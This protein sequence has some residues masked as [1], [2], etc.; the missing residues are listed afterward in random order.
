MGH[1]QHRPDGRHARG[2]HPR[3][4]RLGRLHRI[5]SALVAIIDAGTDYNHPDLAANIWTNPGEIPGNGIDDDG[6]GYVD[7]VHGYDFVNRD[8][9]PMDDNGHGTHVAGTIGAIGDNGVG[10]AGVCW[11][12]K[13]MPLK[14]LDS[15]GFGNTGNAILAVQYATQMHARIMN[16]SWGGGGY[17]EALRLAI[18]AASDAGILF[19][20]AAGNDAADNDTLPHYPANYDVPLV[21]SVASTD[22]FDNLSYFSCY[23]ATTVDLAAP[24]SAILST[25]PNNTYSIYSGTSMATPHVSGALALML[26]R[27]PSMSGADAKQMLLRSVDPLPSLAGRVL[28]GG[29]LNAFTMLAEPDS[30]PPAAITDV[31]VTAVDGSWV[32]LAWTASGDD[33]AVGRASR[34]DVR[35]SLSPITEANF[36]AASAAPGMPYPQPAGTP[37]SVRVNGLAFETPYWFAVKALDEFGNAS[38]M[39]NVASGTTLPGPHVAI[40]PDSL[41][42]DLYTGASTT[43]TLGIANTGASELVWHLSIQETA[44]PLSVAALRSVAAS[45]WQVL[46]QVAPTGANRA[47]SSATVEA[48]RAAFTGVRSDERIL[49]YS[50]EVGRAPGQHYADLALQALGLPYTGIYNDPYSFGAALT[51]GSWDFVFVNHCNYYAVGQWWNE[52]RATC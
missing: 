43:R 19:V 1:A 48:V 27:F 15:G 45:K 50:D 4:E 49:L 29:R 31:S 38:P 23:G 46:G 26:A 8:G 35:Y 13:I 10:V 34:Y 6:N 52:S 9:D 47:G 3:H 28:T 41:V 17:S 24:G 14:F 7:D 39:S 5:E 40:T 37:E 30:I 32:T 44:A 12:V 25:T 11:N 2:G 21:I 18:Q 16:N 20:A 36:D 42:A 51:S 33:G 22:H